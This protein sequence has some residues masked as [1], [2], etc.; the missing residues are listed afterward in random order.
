M[1]TA[2]VLVECAPDAI[3]SLG[4]A[5]AAIDG[6]AEVYSVAGDADLVAIVRTVDNDAIAKIVT[7][8]IA[9]LP[10]LRDT[11]TLIAY[12]QYDATDIDF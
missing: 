11:R 6:V 2:I 7:E 3:S 12:R 9:V 5:L 8:Q 4:P 10:G 1:Q